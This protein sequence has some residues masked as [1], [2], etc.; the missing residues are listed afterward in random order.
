MSSELQSVDFQDF[1]KDLFL[2]EEEKYVF[3]EIDGA[4]FQKPLTPLFASYMVPAL[5]A[6]TLEAFEKLKLPMKQFHAKIANGYFYQTVPMHDDPEARVNEHK[7]AMQHV[8]PRATEILDEYVEKTILPFYSKLDEYKKVELSLE[9]AKKVAL[10]LYEMYRK[11]WSIHFEV[12]MPR[13]SLGVA[14]EE[15][16]GA[17]LQTENTTEV[18]DLL[19]G[20]MNKSLETDR[21]LWKLSLHVKGSSV[22]SKVFEDM[23][24]EQLHAALQDVEEGRAFLA[25]LD[26]FLEEYGYRTAVS[27]EFAEETWVENPYHA[28]KVIK[29]YLEKDFDFE[30]E[31][32]EVIEKREK[33]VEET[34]A[35]MPEGELKETFKALHAMA[36]N[37]WGLDEDHHFYIDA[38]LPAKARPVI[39]NIGQTLAS[40][41][42]IEQKEDVVFLYLDDLVELLQNPTAA[43]ALIEERKEEHRKNEAIT[44][45]PF[46]GPPPEGPVDPIVERVF[47]TKMADLDEET[48][49][50]SGYSGSQGTHTG[51]VKVVSDQS[52]FDKVKKGDILVC[53]T[54]TPPWTVLFNLAGAI[55][56]D[57][58]GILS[59]A[60]TVAREYEVPCVIGTKIATATLKDGDVVTVDGTKGEVIIREQN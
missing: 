53:K 59:H 3:W 37:V 30:A 17:L 52:E 27:H 7:A 16:Y 21:E 28:L 55:V 25:A 58:G 35:R 1:K 45:P 23:D 15:V 33:K 43:T 13:L 12:V 2:A 48:K 49:K 47:G 9:E 18:Y 4:H 54:T 36:L 26:T 44:P 34:L 31:F 57:V 11:I 14:L 6:G 8:F 46:F 51:T 42:I 41:S 60:A 20:V 39:L 56:T 22:L 29:N 24:V 32:Q 19:L 38:M 50:F 5:S 10:E 40:H